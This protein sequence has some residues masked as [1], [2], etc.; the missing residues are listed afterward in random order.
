MGEKLG[1]PL[2]APGILLISFVA[3][4]SGLSVSDFNY[5]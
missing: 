1:V 4:C 3:E 2:D 5:A